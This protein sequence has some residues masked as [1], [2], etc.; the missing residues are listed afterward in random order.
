MSF[1]EVAGVALRGVPLEPLE[2]TGKGG[3]AFPTWSMRSS[4]AGEPGIGGTAGSNL[5][6]PCIVR[7]ARPPALRPRLEECPDCEELGVTSMVGRG[8]IVS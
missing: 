4:P 1:E 6:G 7:S 8:D 3:R 5:N 2:G